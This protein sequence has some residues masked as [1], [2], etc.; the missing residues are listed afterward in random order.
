MRAYPLLAYVLLTV[1]RT[2]A[3]GHLIHEPYRAFRRY[4]RDMYLQQTA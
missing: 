2:A 3:D 4:A 1:A